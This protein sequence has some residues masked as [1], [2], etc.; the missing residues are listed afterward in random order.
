MRS[1]KYVDKI[2][3]LHFSKRLR[4]KYGSAYKNNNGEIFQGTFWLGKYPYFPSRD[5]GLS[6]DKIDEHVPIASA[7]VVMTLSKSAH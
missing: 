1:M 2:I 5:V 6:C 3:Q 7:I 4:K